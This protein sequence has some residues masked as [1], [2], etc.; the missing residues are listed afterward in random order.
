MINKG[1]NN[2]CLKKCIIKIEIIFYY[3]E[4][5]NLTITMDIILNLNQGNFFRYNGSDVEYKTKMLILITPPKG[6]KNGHWDRKDKI[7]I[8][9][10]HLYNY[11]AIQYGE[12]IL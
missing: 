12:I 5:Y 4:R 6:Y 9:P 7:I 10:K 8:V 1:V 3:I 11:V 2:E